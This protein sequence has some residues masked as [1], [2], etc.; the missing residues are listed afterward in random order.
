MKATM[1]DRHKLHHTEEPSLPLNTMFWLD[2]PAAGHFNYMERK[3]DWTFYGVKL[4]EEP[5]TSAATGQPVATV[6]EAESGV[7]SS[8]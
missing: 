5:L 7:G 6:T 4:G 2:C 8:R 3:G 1:D